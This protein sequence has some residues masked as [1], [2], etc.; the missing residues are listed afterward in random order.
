MSSIIQPIR[1]VWLSREKKIEI[2]T[3]MFIT[4]ILWHKSSISNERV[5][6]QRRPG[7][8]I[9]WLA[10]SLLWV[11]IKNRSERVS[12]FAFLSLRRV[13]YVRESESKWKS[14]LICDISRYTNLKR[15]C[16]TIWIWSSIDEIE[17]HNYTLYAH[18]IRVQCKRWRW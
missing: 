3:E 11:Y 18:L 16:Y 8:I 13:S 14:I 17:A 5:S 7:S 2:E 1:L 4:Q 15:I 9:Q 10:K 12:W 6:L